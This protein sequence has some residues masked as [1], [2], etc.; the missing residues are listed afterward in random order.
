[1]TR[2]AGS[3]FTLAEIASAIAILAVLLGVIYAGYG[4]GVRSWERGERVHAAVTELR[5]AGRFIR[6]RVEQAYPLAV[7]AGNGQRL[8][9][10][11]EAQRLSL[12]TWLPGYLG[13]AGLY[14]VVFAVDSR[15]TGVD[16][17]MSRRRLM[18]APSR[19]ADIDR[20][21]RL[22]VRDLAAVR[23]EYFGSTVDGVPPAWHRRWHARQRL[24]RLVRL[25]L[26]S[27]R[28][29]EWPAIVIVVHSE[30]PLGMRSASIPD[31]D[32]RRGPSIALRLGPGDTR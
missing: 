20:Q 2:G 9:F 13:E 3:S 28:V 21:R 8:R 14:Q 6:D 1:V 27:Q 22:L 23:F 16:L 15:E 5:L 32:G 26:T 24:P 31:S 11:G 25:R 4:L 7:T 10:E 30:V 17:S 18:L 12:V 19:E 29:G